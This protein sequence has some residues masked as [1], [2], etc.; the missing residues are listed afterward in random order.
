MAGEQPSSH[1]RS[2]D[3][4][5]DD[6][7]GSAGVRSPTAGLHGNAP[8]GAFSSGVRAPAASVSAAHGRVLSVAREVSPENL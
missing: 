2:P 5:G 1:C 8:A 7:L 6:G 4:R 3:L